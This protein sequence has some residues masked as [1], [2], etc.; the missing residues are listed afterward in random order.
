[1]KEHDNPSKKSTQSEREQELQQ[2]RL[3][4]RFDW[5][6]LIE[7]KIQEGQENGIFDD[8]KGK[9][10]PLNLS[11]NPYDKERKLAHSLLK[12][13]RMTPAWIGSRNH[14]TTQIDQ[15]RKEMARVWQRHEREYKVL[16]DERYRDSLSISWDDQC[17]KWENQI[18]TLNKL[19]SDYNLKRPIDNLEIIKLE[20]SRELQ[21]INAVRWLRSIK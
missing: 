8:L 16:K 12:D 10:K 9:G 3:R 21:R 11:Q 7:E 18:L 17:Q 5:D 13:N 15:L 19:I 20:L 4:M 14:I 2:H 1:M 6:N